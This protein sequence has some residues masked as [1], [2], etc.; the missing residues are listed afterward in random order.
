MGIF[1]HN[2]PGQEWALSL[3]NNHI[4]LILSEKELA[5]FELSNTEGGT[6]ALTLDM[7]ALNAPLPPDLL[8]G[9]QVV[10]IEVDGAIPFSIDRIAGIRRQYPDLPV[11]AAIRDAALPL[12][13][14]LLKNGVADVVGLPLSYADLSEVLQQVLAS[15]CCRTSDRSA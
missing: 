8:N 9:S 6:I 5:A 1:D 7:L 2:K 11:V 4:H 12:V 14:T 15:T 13:R 3:D 10:V